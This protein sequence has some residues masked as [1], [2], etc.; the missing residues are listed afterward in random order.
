MYAE[1][2]ISIVNKM[3]TKPKLRKTC[4]EIENK[5]RK[6]DSLVSAVSLIRFPFFIHTETVALI[7]ITLNTIKAFGN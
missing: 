7:A 2:I 3:E 1:R 4:F 5:E 6:T